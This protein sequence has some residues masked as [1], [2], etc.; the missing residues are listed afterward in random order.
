MVGLFELRYADSV[1]SIN[2]QI[3]GDICKPVQMDRSGICILDN[4]LYYASLS[5]RP[6]PFIISQTGKKSLRVSY[7]NFG[8]CLSLSLLRLINRST[9]IIFIIK[10]QLSRLSAQL[11]KFSFQDAKIVG[12]TDIS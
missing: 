2:L 1:V 4:L 7:E 12:I 11:S 9:V 5:Q 8:K 6:K 3:V 10:K